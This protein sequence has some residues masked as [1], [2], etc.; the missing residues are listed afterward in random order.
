MIIGL[1]G[2]SGSA[3]LEVA[4]Q[5]FNAGGGR[6]SLFS[7]ARASESGRVSFLRDV[8]RGTDSARLDSGVVYVDVLTASEAALIRQAGGSIWHVQGVVSDKVSINRFDLM[9]TP[10]QQGDRHFRPVVE[11]LGELV[12]RKRQRS[13]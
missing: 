11:A 9:V 3:R 5:V 1:C 6:F 13:A 2:G 10:T 7:S 4:E 12:I 8:L